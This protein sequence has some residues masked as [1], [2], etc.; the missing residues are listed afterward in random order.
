MLNSFLTRKVRA[1]LVA[2][3]ALIFINVADIAP[4]ATLIFGGD[5][6][7][8]RGVAR[9]IGA[10]DAAYPFTGIAPYLKTADLA[11]ANL[12]C[13]LAGPGEGAPLVKKFVFHAD[14][15]MAATLRG[16]GFTAMTLA[17]NHS[18][19]Y[20]RDAV[21]ATMRH[22]EAA[23]ITPIGAGR[24]Q[25]DAARARYFDVGGMKVAVLGFVA[26]P[27]EGLFTSAGD[28]PGPAFADPDR[29]AAAIREAKAHADFV[30]VTMHWGT[31]YRPRPDPKQREL[32]RLMAAAGA[33]LIVG[34][35]P[36]VLQSIEYIGAVPVLYSLGNLVFD[37]REP[38][39]SQSILLRVNLAPGQPPRLAVLPLRIVNSRP[40]PADPAGAAAIAAAL[41]STSPAPVLTPGPD[42]WIELRSGAI[43]N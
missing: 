8:D 43:G 36:H 13:P 24:D 22:L 34:H 17:N 12:E 40:E 23:G 16:A 6:L 29:V 41:A 14:P 15:E 20:G 18:S 27:L 9:A 11:L 38:E 19:D 32:A 26:M 31:E 42:A 1:T 25:P 39:R 10:H 33:D 2:I 3:L 5:V 35:H 37:Q 21:L 4:A 28:L 30:A 7:L